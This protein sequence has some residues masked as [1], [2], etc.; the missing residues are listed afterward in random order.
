MDKSVIKVGGNLSK[1][2]LEKL[3]E[4][5]NMG[6]WIATDKNVIWEVIEDE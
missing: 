2:E 3:V 1:E 5:L 6:H 4:Q